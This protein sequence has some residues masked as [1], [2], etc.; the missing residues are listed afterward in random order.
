MISMFIDDVNS[1]VFEESFYIH[2]FYFLLVA[3]PLIGFWNLFGELVGVVLKGL[4]ER[5]KITK[6]SSKSNYE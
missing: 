1:G 4:I 3:I 2:Y 5:L 6:V